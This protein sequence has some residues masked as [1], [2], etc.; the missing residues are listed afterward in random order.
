MFA[1]LALDNAVFLFAPVRY[2]PGQE[3]SLQNAGRMTFLLM[4]RMLLL[5]VVFGAAFATGGLVFLLVS[6]V[7]DLSPAIAY[8]A[9]FSVGWLGLVALNVLLVIVGAGLFSRFDVARDRG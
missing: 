7:L 8:G 2:V 3:G 5:I 1:W 9:G 4:L 6:D